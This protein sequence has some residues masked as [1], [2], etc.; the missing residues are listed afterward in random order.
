MIR[1]RWGGK[2]LWVYE[3]KEEQIFNLLLFKITGQL[4]CKTVF[5]FPSWCGLLFGEEI[6]AGHFQDLGMVMIAVAIGSI[7]MSFRFIKLMKD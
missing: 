1:K 2:A 4:S 7:L 6:T 3:K 5:C